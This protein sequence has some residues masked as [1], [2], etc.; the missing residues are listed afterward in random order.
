MN[1]DKLSPPDA[2][3]ANVH[4]R[5]EP[6]SVLDGLL[7]MREANTLSVYWIA[8]FHKQIAKTE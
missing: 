2:Q 7:F 4:I 3:I 8:I 5:M 1:S 6:S